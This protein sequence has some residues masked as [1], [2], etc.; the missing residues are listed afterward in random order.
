VKLVVLKKHEKAKAFQHQKE[1]KSKIPAD[2]KKDVTHTSSP[3]F[4]TSGEG[5]F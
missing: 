4:S 3:A 1:K 5:A 2:E